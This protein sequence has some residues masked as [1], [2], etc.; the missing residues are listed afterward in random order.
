MNVNCC[1]AVAFW[2][3][4]LSHIATHLVLVLGETLFKESLQFRHFKSDE[5]PQPDAALS[6]PF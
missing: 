5:I 2:I 3:R 4:N 1:N 6:A